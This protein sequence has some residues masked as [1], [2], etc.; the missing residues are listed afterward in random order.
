MYN[1]SQGWQSWGSAMNLCIHVLDWLKFSRVFNRDKNFKTGQNFM[2]FCRYNH[3]KS[4]ILSFWLGNFYKLYFHL[5]LKYKYSSCT[6]SIYI[7]SITTIQLKSHNAYIVP[8]PLQAVH[9]KCCLYMY[10][11]NVKFLRKKYVLNLIEPIFFIKAKVHFL[12]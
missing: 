1:I 9:S 5:S 3:S 11:Q 2:E 4:W 12:T 10:D 8:M 7:W 6:A